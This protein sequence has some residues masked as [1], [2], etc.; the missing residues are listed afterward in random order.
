MV[1]NKQIKANQKNALSSTGPKTAQ[2]LQVVSQNALQHGVY[3]SVSPVLPHEDEQAYKHLKQ[4]LIA[5][6]QAISIAELALIE[7]MAQCLWKKQRLVVLEQQMLQGQ[8][9][10][11]A[12]I[13]QEKRLAHQCSSL[14]EKSKSCIKQVQ[15][16]IQDLSECIEACDKFNR[17][18]SATKRNKEAEFLL[19]QL[20][21]AINTVKSSLSPFLEESDW[22]EAQKGEPISITGKVAKGIVCNLVCAQHF[23]EE[24]D[25]CQWYSTHSLSQLMDALKEWLETLQKKSELVEE[26]FELSQRLESIGEDFMLNEANQSKLERYE[27]YLDNQFYKALHELQKLQAFNLQKRQYS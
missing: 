9:A 17:I 18:R 10:N 24:Q 19:W 26:R 7:K 1:S 16:A 8:Q 23:E 15:A 6:F 20:Q 2:G 4:Q 14:A 3:S 22:R 25:S 12:L 21:D 27:G 11:Q 5:D 13:K